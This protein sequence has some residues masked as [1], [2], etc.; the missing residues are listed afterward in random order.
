MISSSKQPKLTD[1]KDFKLFHKIESELTSLGHN[2]RELV[3]YVNLIIDFMNDY[4]ERKL[5]VAKQQV[6]TAKKKF[7]ADKSNLKNQHEYI[8]VLR[9]QTDI[10]SRKQFV[11]MM[12][13]QDERL[14]TAFDKH[15][16]S[17]C[18]ND[19]TIIPDDVTF[20][21]QKLEKLVR[22][23]SNNRFCY[24]TA[25][26]LSAI[27]RCIDTAI[28][29]ILYHENRIQDQA[30]LKTLQEKKKELL[31]ARPLIKE[32]IDSHIAVFKTNEERRSKNEKPH[33]NLSDSVTQNSVLNGS[34][35]MVDD[36]KEHKLSAST[37]ADST[38]NAL[39]HDMRNVNKSDATD[40]HNDILLASRMY[41]NELFNQNLIKAEEDVWVDSSLLLNLPILPCEQ[42][43]F[44]TTVKGYFD[45]Y[46]ADKVFT[47]PR[48]LSYSIAERI[49]GLQ[50]FT[51]LMTYI[52]QDALTK[53]N[54]FATAIKGAIELAIDIVKD[55]MI[56]YYD[57]ATYW[58]KRYE[59][60][61]AAVIARHKDRKEIMQAQKEEKNSPPEEKGNL[62][63]KAI[64]TLG[65]FQVVQS[66]NVP[67]AEEKRLM[68]CWREAI[69]KVINSLEHEIKDCYGDKSLK[70]KKR[71]ALN[72][73]LPAASLD[74]LQRLAAT[75]VKKDKTICKGW[76]SRTAEIMS[77][78]EKKKDPRYLQRSTPVTEIFANYPRM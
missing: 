69:E 30:L 32:C 34:M 43:N 27:A 74:E 18:D 15:W 77:F 42:Q 22:Q 54:K 64:T 40:S 76:T 1:I 6:E 2:E 4:D 65:V 20:R 17:K 47:V 9:Y 72:S 50:N 53:T 71:D 13:H 56:Y 55:E 38:T 37:L 61:T 48:N 45:G 11:F 66:T 28:E 36:D 5:E 67:T 35:L 73:L 14:F 58:C 33:Q 21:R 49:K 7:L 3:D 23:F 60:N 70:I 52:V 12:Q 39:L 44:N 41:F 19:S 78:I 46:K 8:R 25:D 62:G 26:D 16:Q 29:V 59:K 75:A 51:L 68:E 57:P 31:A 24:L 10:E 63:G